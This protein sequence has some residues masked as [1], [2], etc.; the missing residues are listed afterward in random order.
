M[1]ITLTVAVFFSALGFVSMALGWFFDYPTI[2][3]VGAL[4]FV[5]LGAVVMD[6]G[7][8]YRTGETWT[9][10]N[11]YTTDVEYQYGQVPTPTEFPLGFVVF[12]L[13]AL[14]VLRGLDRY[15]GV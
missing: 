2:S 10:Q 15:S 12:L 9:E 13:G 5:A 6:G 8:A 4:M 3:I 14:G 1:A 11:S 7:L